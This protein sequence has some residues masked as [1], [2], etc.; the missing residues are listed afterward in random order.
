MAAFNHSE[1]ARMSYEKGL[2]NLIVFL[3]AHYIEAFECLGAWQGHRAILVLE[4]LMVADEL[5]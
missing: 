3:F 5:G 1:D 4:Y 2:R